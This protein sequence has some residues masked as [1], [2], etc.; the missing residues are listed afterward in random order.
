MLCT[1]TRTYLLRLAES[2]NTLLLT[3]GELPKKPP[4]EGPPATITIST[5][6]SA[7]YELV[8]TAPRA[9]A[10]PALLALCPYR[11][12]PGE[13]AGDMDVEGAAVEGAQVKG[14]QPTARRLTWAQLEAAVQCS[15][16]ELQTAL[17]RAR[18]LEVDGGRWC[19]LEAQ[20]EQD[21]CGSLL[22]LLVEKEWPLDAMPLREAVE[23]MADGGYDELAV[24]HCARAL[25]TSRLAG[26]AEWGGALR[27][28]TLA[29][30]VE[31]MCRFRAQGSRSQGP[32]A[33]GDGSA[34]SARAVSLG[35]LGRASAPR[36]RCLGHARNSP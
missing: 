29:L 11:D 14:V 2:S 9:S 30:D 19:V 12:S 20:Y 10:L 4:T 5:S 36:E 3:P 17:Q 13:G 1:A 21:V 27:Q 25:S 34:P 28:Q 24:R 6:A 31:A 18:A 23:A 32:S 33:L 7:Y 16:A 15:G 8:P 35:V 22:D 26:W